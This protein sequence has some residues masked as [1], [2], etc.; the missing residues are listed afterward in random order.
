MSQDNIEYEAK[1]LEINV[2]NIVK[3]LQEVG[4]VEGKTYM[5]RRYV[6]DTIPAVV[7]PAFHICATL[8]TIMNH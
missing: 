1:I 6:F 2:D 8:V 4:A 5:F 3:K 7:F